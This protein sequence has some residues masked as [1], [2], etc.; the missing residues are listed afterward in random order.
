MTDRQTTYK[1]AKVKG[2]VHWP[3]EKWMHIQTTA[4]DFNVPNH[5]VVMDLLNF[6]L[7]DTGRQL[8]FR[9]FLEG[10]YP[11][12]AVQEGTHTS[13][14]TSSRLERGIVICPF[15]KVRATEQH[16][17]TIHRYQY[18]AWKREQELTAPKILV[19]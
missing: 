6:I 7:Q 5:W 11:R 12:K 19:R 1:E 10:K 15:C 17:K 16:I 13:I 14:V 18:T 8:E 2:Y 4:K 9:N 3:V